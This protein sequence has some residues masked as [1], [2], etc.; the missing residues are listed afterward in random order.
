M[1]FV[2]FPPAIPHLLQLY[3]IPWFLTMFTRE[4]TFFFH[5]N[6]EFLKDDFSH[7]VR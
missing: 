5:L 3:A 7:L 2:L 6:V 1:L 4:Y